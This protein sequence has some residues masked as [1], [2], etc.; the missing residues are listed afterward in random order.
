MHTKALNTMKKIF[1]V[2][3]GVFVGIQTTVSKPV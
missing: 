2:K 1:K 3:E